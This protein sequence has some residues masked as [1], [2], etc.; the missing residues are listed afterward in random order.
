MKEFERGGALQHLLLRYTQAL[1]T[2]IA[3]T[4]MCNRHHSV[5]EHLCRWL[6][7]CLDRTPGNELHMTQELIAHTLGVRR[8]SVTE[9]MGNLQRTGLIQYRSGHIIVVNRP[10]L[11]QQACECY[12]LI[13]KEYARLLTERAQ[14][15]VGPE[16]LPADTVQTG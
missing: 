1:I 15:P 8:E 13:Q 7:L 14:V 4:A 11:E 12:T 3:Q 10:G 16:S 5:A 2:Q 9:A 6:L